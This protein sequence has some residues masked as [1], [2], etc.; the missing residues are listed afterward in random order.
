LAK[1]KKQ[2]IWGEGVKTMKSRKTNHYRVGSVLIL[3][4]ISLIIL[5]ALGVGILSSSYGVRHRAIMAK[6]ETIA[7][8]AAEA[9]YEKVIYWMSQQPDVL[10]ELYE[11]SDEASGTLT[12]PDASCKYEIKLHSFD[13]SRPIYEVTS[14]GSSGMFNR[15]VRVLTLQAIGGWEGTFRVP[16]GPSSSVSWPFTSGEEIHIPIHV[17]K[18]NDSP[19]VIDLNIDN[20]GFYELVSIGEAKGSKYP[21]TIMKCFKAGVCFNQPDSKITNEDSLETKVGRYKDS[22]LDKF[23]FQPDG[24]ELKRADN[25]NITTYPAVQIELRVNNGV[26]E[27]RITNDCTVRGIW[28]T[29][30]GYAGSNVT[31]DYKI[32]DFYSDGESYKK[33]A[34]YAYHLAPIT[35]A[36]ESTGWIP[37]TDTYVTQELHGVKAEPGGQIYVDGSVVIGGNHD[38]PAPFDDQVVKGKVTIVATEN[39]WIADPIK[40]YGARDGSM[41]AEDNPNVIG[42]ISQK[43]I[44]KVVDPGLSRNLLNDPDYTSK[45]LQYAPVCRRDSGSKPEDERHLYE[46]VEVEAAINVGG[47]G[48]GAEN[49]GNR[50]RGS[51]R[52]TY[53]SASYSA[54]GKMIVRGSIAE[55]TRGIVGCAVPLWSG[56]ISGY[57]K[58]YYHDKRLLQ[59]I[60]PGDVSLTGKFIPAP[61]GWNDYRAQY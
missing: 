34:V 31:Y 24:E 48:W 44:I 55:A 58:H 3:V 23:K 42:L 5:T 25:S 33:Y 12:F 26:G 27:I 46:S 60:L 2:K 32:D 6:N 43:G 14:Y 36:P 7:M 11:D 56:Y 16:S 17:N 8:L 49:V 30:P 35:P 41:P 51:R 15:T 37:L 13:G 21:Y 22:T 39:I 57:S 53:Y 9:G 29:D 61:A 54:Y 19:D 10:S 45:G 47:G 28:T 38:E 59:G 4:M 20:A 1:I 40:V 50:K 52:T 18:F